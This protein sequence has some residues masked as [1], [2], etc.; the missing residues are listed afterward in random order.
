MRITEVEIHEFD[1]EVARTGTV[2][3]RRTMGTNAS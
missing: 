3:S 2:G 1:Y